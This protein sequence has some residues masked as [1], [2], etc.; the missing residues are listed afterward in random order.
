MD[1]S[2]WRVCEDSISWKDY[3]AEDAEKSAERYA[4][5]DPEGEEVLSDSEGV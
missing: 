4:A 2:L 3:L 1:S 5:M